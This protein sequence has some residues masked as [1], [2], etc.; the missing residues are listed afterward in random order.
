M[1]FRIS[2]TIF[3]FVCFLSI[4]DCDT[5]GNLVDN[6]EPDTS[7]IDTTYETV[8]KPNIYIYPQNKIDLD[9][10]ISF[11][12]GGSITTSIPD[13]NDGWHITIDSTGLI[14]SKYR[15]LF[16]ESDIPENIESVKLLIVK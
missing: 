5:N 6:S 15:F 9:V 7:S 12:N 1:I 8:R 14:N 3:I 2:L 13:Y 11:P 4:T 16:Y 10:L